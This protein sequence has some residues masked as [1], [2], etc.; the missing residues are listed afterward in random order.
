MIS[1]AE[2]LRASSPHGPAA[3]ATARQVLSTLLLVDVTRDLLER[4]GT[5][6]VGWRIRT[7]DAI[8]VVSAT[9]AQERLRALITYDERM[10]KV[11]EALGF[12][13]VAP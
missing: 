3:M 8:H 2:L 6:N 4:A 9:T 10:A 11:A 13:A 7:L 12:T 1:H 5:L